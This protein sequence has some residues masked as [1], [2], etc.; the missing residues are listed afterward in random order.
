[1]NNLVVAIEYDG[2][3]F[4]GSQKQPNTRTVQGAFD[5]PSSHICLIWKPDT[6]RSQYL[7]LLISPSKPS[8]ELM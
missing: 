5:G 6:A 8:H 1:M 7:T 2:T 4:Q 3:K